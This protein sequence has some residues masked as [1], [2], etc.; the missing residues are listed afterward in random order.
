MS[1]CMTASDR[2]SA[3]Q[4]AAARV[5]STREG[6]GFAIR[7]WGAGAELAAGQLQ[8]GLRRLAELAD[9]AESVPASYWPQRD[10]YIERVQAERA[11]LAD[12]VDAI[13]GTVARLG[14]LVE[15]TRER[16][17]PMA[18]NGV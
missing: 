13:N 16:P 2:L 6:L 11:E 8:H 14:R 10:W 7:G 5:T 3:L 12:I 17:V 4:G 18:E 9:L 1:D 15:G